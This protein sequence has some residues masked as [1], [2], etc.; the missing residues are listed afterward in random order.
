MDGS[1]SIIITEGNIILLTPSVSK[2]GASLQQSGFQTRFA[3]NSSLRM[4][5]AV[6]KAGF[7][8]ALLSSRAWKRGAVYQ[9]NSVFKTVTDRF[10]LIKG[11]KTA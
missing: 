1:S 9:E 6:S 5:K 10:R 2:A 7:K 11:F 4:L 8:P 3:L